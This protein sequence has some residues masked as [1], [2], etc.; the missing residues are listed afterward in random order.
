MDPS[1]RDEYKQRLYELTPPDGKSIGNGALRDLLKAAFQH[2]QFTQD[3]YFDLRNSLRAEGKLERGRGKGGSVHRL[4]SAEGPEGTE[5]PDLARRT[6]QVP[7]CEYVFMRTTVDLPDT[8][9]R[10][11]K[12][13]AALRG[14]TMKELIVH[15][16]EREVETQPR[17][18]ENRKLPIMIWKG[19]RKLDLSDFD[20]DDLL[21]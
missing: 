17:Q 13:T 15:A 8:L 21:A 5:D 1:R 12:A 10:K 20:F 3:D 11:T 6:S 4:L 7:L 19:K 9:F 2:D 18:D 14:S 16:L